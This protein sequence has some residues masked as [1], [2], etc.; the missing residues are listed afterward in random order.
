M[1][2]VA[3]Q[4]GSPVPCAAVRVT[5]HETG[6]ARSAA[7]NDAGGYTFSTIP[8]GTYDVT[9]TKTGFQSYTA[10][11]LALSADQTVRVDTSLRVG[12]V[13]ESVEV[14]AQALQNVP[15]PLGQNYQNLFI[16][17]PGLTPPANQHSVAVN[18]SRGLT[19]NSNGSR[20]SW[21]TL[22]H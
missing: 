19:F 21:L 7:A 10:R 9:V 20:A 5:H 4:S 16:E 15:V 13:S 3:D 17:L 1:G 2:T 14:S 12:A 22:Y 6:Q 18:P 11:D 8:P